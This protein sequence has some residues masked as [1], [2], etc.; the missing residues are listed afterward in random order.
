MGLAGSYGLLH[1]LALHVAVQQ[2]LATAGICSHACDHPMIIKF[3]RECDS[4]SGCPAAEA[5]RRALVACGSHQR[6]ASNT[7]NDCNEYGDSR[8]RGS[9]GAPLPDPRPPWAVPRSHD[10]RGALRGCRTCPCRAERSRFPASLEWRERHPRAAPR[11]CRA[12]GAQVRKVVRSQPP[13]ARISG[14]A[15]HGPS[16]CVDSGS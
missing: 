6:P 4:I 1:G 5:G 10:A 9:G 15:Q 16:P 12:P 14:S 7:L 3:G 2:Q 8:G 11:S 13:T